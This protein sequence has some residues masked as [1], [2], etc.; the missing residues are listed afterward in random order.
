MSNHPYQLDR[1]TEFVLNAQKFYRLSLVYLEL[2]VDVARNNVPD[3]FL[4]EVRAHREALKSLGE[5]W[6]DQRLDYQHCAY[7]ARRGRERSAA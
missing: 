3:C 5:G 7:C 6:L 4:D 2:L 1:N